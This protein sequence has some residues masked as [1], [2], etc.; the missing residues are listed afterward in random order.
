MGIATGG[1]MAFVVPAKDRGGERDDFRDVPLTDGGNRDYS[2]RGMLGNFQTDAEPFPTPA[3]VRIFTGYGGDRADL[4]RGYVEPVIREDPA[5]DKAN[6]QD[7]WTQPR[8]PN[9][10]MGETD[11][12]RQDFEFRGRN[13]RARG[14]LTRP[15]VPTERG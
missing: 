2:D 8:E 10:D 7:R 6:Y 3:G 15:R 13:Q 9:E 11:V 1:F 14:F 5:Y 4:E 12:M